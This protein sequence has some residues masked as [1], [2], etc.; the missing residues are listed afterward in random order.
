MPTLED[1]IEFENASGRIPPPTEAL[2]LLERYSFIG[3]GQ[4]GGVILS[5][6]EALL[7]LAT[8]WFITLLMGWRAWFLRLDDGHVVVVY[9]T[10]HKKPYRVFPWD[11]PRFWAEPFG[12]DFKEWLEQAHSVIESWFFALIE[13]DLEK[14]FL[15][16]S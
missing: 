4:D 3:R 6:R 10:G 9:D 8:V 7:D 5:R 12:S 15:G 13:G 16:V 1:I 2:D 14:Q 11:G